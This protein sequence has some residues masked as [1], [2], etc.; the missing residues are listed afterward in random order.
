MCFCLV[1]GVVASYFSYEGDIKVWYRGEGA[2]YT[3][4]V[5]NAYRNQYLMIVDGGFL[6]ELVS[7]HNGQSIV[8]QQVSRAD[9]SST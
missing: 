2:L 5:L 4:I 1:P 3:S 6:S 9:L 8:K 7:S